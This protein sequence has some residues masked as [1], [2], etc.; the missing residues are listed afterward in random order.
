MKKFLSSEYFDSI[1]KT[2]ACWWKMFVEVFFGKEYTFSCCSQRFNPTF[3]EKR[4]VANTIQRKLC[5]KESPLLLK[6]KIQEFWIP[7]CLQQLVCGR[8]NSNFCK[9]TFFLE[10]PAKVNGIM[11]ASFCLVI[12]LSHEFRL[13]LWFVLCLLIS[14]DGTQKQL[15]K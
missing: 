12:N 8:I 3:I 9:K 4:L 5:E 11:F 7:L 1:A 10:E 6:I 13:A 2:V 15:N 14:I